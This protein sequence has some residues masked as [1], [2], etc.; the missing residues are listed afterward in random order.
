M[1]LID[2][3]TNV[4]TVLLMLPIKSSLHLCIDLR[5]YLGLMLNKDTEKER[6]IYSLWGKSVAKTFLAAGGEGRRK[7]SDC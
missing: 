7:A 5:V 2:N 4:A 3:E 1:L 6:S